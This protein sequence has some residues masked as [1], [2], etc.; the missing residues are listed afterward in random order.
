MSKYLPTVNRWDLPDDLN[1]ILIKIGQARH[2][3]ITGKITPEEHAKRWQELKSHLAALISTEVAKA[4]T[5]VLKKFKAAYATDL[6]TDAYSALEAI[7]AEVES[8]EV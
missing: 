6:S 7:I 5:E 1:D 2:E 8:N 4:T 3:A